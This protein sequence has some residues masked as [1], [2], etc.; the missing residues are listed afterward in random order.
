[1]YS[2]DSLQSPNFNGLG[3]LNRV[4][5]NR[6]S[7]CWRLL[8]PRFQGLSSLNRVGKNWMYGCHSLQLP[9]WDGLGNI[10]TFESDWMEKVGIL[11]TRDAGDRREQQSIMVTY[12]A[13]RGVWT[14]EPGIRFIEDEKD[15][16]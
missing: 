2:C 11:Q 5:S 4:G 13:E 6:I 3:K 7:A 10:R 8:N 15:M 1:M 9:D 12:I 14:R 16:N